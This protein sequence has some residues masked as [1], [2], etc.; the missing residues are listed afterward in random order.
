MRAMLC[1][2]LLGGTVWAQSDAGNPRELGRV[3]WIRDFDA[4]LARA[5]E[6]D[7]PMLLLFQE[8]PG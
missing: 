4:G 2:C 1:L 7:K 5:A 8:V 6:V 3:G